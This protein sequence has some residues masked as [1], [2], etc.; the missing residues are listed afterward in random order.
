MNFEGGKRSFPVCTKCDISPFSP[1]YILQCLGFSCEEAVAPP[2][3]L[4]LCTDLWTHRSGLVSLDQMGINP[5]TTKIA[6]RRN[7]LRKKHP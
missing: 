5:T 7:I 2:A 4:R 3:V 6:C 1:Q